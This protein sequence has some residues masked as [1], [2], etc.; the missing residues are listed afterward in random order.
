[1]FERYEKNEFEGELI[2]SDL[3]VKMVK[4]C[5]ER[6]LLKYGPING[7]FY[8]DEKLADNK[9]HSYFSITPCFKNKYANSFKFIKCLINK[10]EGGELNKYFFNCREFEDFSDEPIPDPK[11]IESV[12]I[13][14]NI[15]YHPLFTSPLSM[16]SIRNIATSEEYEKS[17]ITLYEKDN[18]KIKCGLQLLSM[19]HSIDGVD[20]TFEAFDQF[21]VLSINKPLESIE[22]SINE[23]KE[24]IE[25]LLLLF[26]FWVRKRISYFKYYCIVKLR[27]DKGVWAKEI[28]NGNMKVVYESDRE[29]FYQT[30]EHFKVF[31]KKSCP[32]LL[33]KIEAY[34]LQEAIWDYVTSFEAKY[35]EKN[36]MSLCTCLEALKDG[37]LKAN[38]KKF[39]LSNDQFKK[40]KKEICT[41]I[42]EYAADNNIDLDIIRYIIE[43]LSDLRHPTFKSIIVD[44]ITELKVRISDLE[45]QKIYDFKPFRDELFHKGKIK[46]DDYEQFEIEKDRLRLLIERIILRIL[47]FPESLHAYPD[48]RVDSNDKLLFSKDR[49]IK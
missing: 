1:M 22:S 18:K 46:E 45:G 47:E 30:F 27:D 15:N 4:V 33:N 7:Y 25:K 13:R 49:Y 39:C 48:R 2:W 9:Y 12:S 44:L 21:L 34:N 11:D 14:F 31:I 36:F 16:K 41:F 8:C 42:K 40:L 28:V 32:V 6:D 19:D 35:V 10:S 26:S 38:K 24:L 17:L 37:H 5:V 3:S 43:K 29:E 20:G 23:G